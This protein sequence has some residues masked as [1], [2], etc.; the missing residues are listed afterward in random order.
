MIDVLTP[1][2]LLALIAVAM[3]T[4]LIVGHASTK[5]LIILANRVFGLR[6]N[7]TMDSESARFFVYVAIGVFFT[8]VYS[9][10][11]SLFAL[12]NQ[13][14]VLLVLVFSVATEVIIVLRKILVDKV[15]KSLLLEGIV[16]R[17]RMLL[18]NRNNAFL[19]ILFVVGV[20]WYFGPAI[21]LA[22]YPG[23]DDRGYLLITKEIIDKGTALITIDYPYVLPYNEH[24]LNAAFMV[25]ASFTYNLYQIVGLQISL[26]LID[27]TLS[28]LF[29]SLISISIYLF[30]NAMSRN[31]AYSMITGITSVF[32]WRSILMYFNWGGVGESLGYF[33]IPLFAFVDYRL[34]NEILE[35]RRGMRALIGVSV[36]KAGLLAFA[37]YTSVYSAFLFLFLV[38][39]VT[40]LW[41]LSIYSMSGRN[42][43]PEKVKLYLKL[44]AP[45]LTLVLGVAALITISVTILQL[46]GIQNMAITWLYDLLIPRT[47]EMSNNPS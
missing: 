47:E 3:G 32:L 38:T 15:D 11:L 20:V 2:M 12:L 37:S 29:L 4:Y 8:V 26:P 31:R 36:V 34:N 21:G 43:I 7:L 40:P 41:S 25:V 9:L 16:R 14:G 45:Y 6:I 5:L 35:N 13:L 17:F 42:R 23:G 30:T 28:L 39:V 19:L 44:I 10:L 24:V 22:S 46:A 18:N 27:L 1:L 33:L